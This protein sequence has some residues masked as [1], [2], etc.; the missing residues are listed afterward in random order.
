MKAEVWNYK[1][2]KGTARGTAAAPPS[3]SAAHRMLLCA[4]FSRGESAIRGISDN[5]DVCATVDCLTA[6]G[7]EIERAGDTLRT[8]GCVPEGADPITLPCRECGSTLRF[9]IPPA[10][11]RTG[12]T[13]FIGS[14]TLFARPL[15]VYDALCRERGLTFDLHET[16]LT[17]RGR[18][19]CGAFTVPGNVSS[20]FVSGLLFALPMVKGESRL[21]V[22]PPVE[23]R[24]YIDMTLETIRRF[25]IDVREAQENVFVIPGGQTYRSGDYT[26]EGDWSNAAFL[27][28]LNL[29]GGSVTVTGLRTDSL[30][31][32][33]VY[34]DYFAALDAG[35]PV[36]DL[37]DC[38]DLGPVCMAVAAA[39]HG[40][41]FHGTRRLRIKESDRCD[42]MARELIKC[43]VTCDIG[44][45]TMEIPGGM[46]HAPDVP[47]YGHN[48]H[49]IVMALSVLLTLIGGSIEGAE[50]VRK[51]FPDFFKRLSLLGIEVQKNG[52]DS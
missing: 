31:G 8:R 19:E 21:C 2:I 18:L 22:T 10:L 47:L 48:D 35:H 13:H 29:F 9:L 27:D 42:A 36:L 17:V 45:D 23:S 3:K 14:P 20:Q 11:L 43:G 24:P 6:L 37:S 5:E 16:S 32:D 26:V 46:L 7:A 30:Q 41:T 40:A 39:K 33:K 44:D 1:I 49:R 38:P 4:G 51:S 25:G 50:A 34:R 12:E 28:A 52:M 15:I